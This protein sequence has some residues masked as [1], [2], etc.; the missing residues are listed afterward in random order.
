MSPETQSSRSTSEWRAIVTLRRPRIPFSGA[1]GLFSR[2]CS[3][4][5]LQR[6]YLIR[7]S[8]K[9][10]ERVYLSREG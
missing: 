4:N 8:Q 6:N 10:D 2:Q 3:P 9:E 7:V 5:N 1:S